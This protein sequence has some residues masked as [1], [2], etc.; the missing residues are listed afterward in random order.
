MSKYIAFEG[1]PG[2]GKTTI[3]KK[4]TL[5]GMTVVPQ[6]YFPEAESLSTE[7]EN[8]QAYLYGY[9]ENW[10]R[11]AGNGAPVV[12]MDRIFISTLAYSYAKEKVLGVGC[13]GLVMDIVRGLLQ[14]GYFKELSGMIIFMARLETSIDRRKKFQN[15][16][17]YNIWFNVE[18][19]RH[20]YEY[21]YFRMWTD[22]YHCP[23]FTIET[24]G[25]TAEQTEM[26]VKKII[27]S[28]TS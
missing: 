20:Y 5:Q 9:A 11:A 24:D 16:K 28:I 3:T 8:K 27:K 6:L 13:Y 1:M 12:I 2:T 22:F 21:Y 10:S 25:L 17:E 23:V 18:F 26:E 7:I 14:K 19:L 15:D 4:I